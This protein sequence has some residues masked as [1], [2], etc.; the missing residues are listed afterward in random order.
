MTVVVWE[1]VVSPVMV[2]YSVDITP[3]CGAVCGAMVTELCPCTSPKKVYCIISD[4]RT[5]KW[6]LRTLTNAHIICFQLGGL[7]ANDL[8]ML[9]Q[10]KR[11]L[12]FEGQGDRA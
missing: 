9:M 3:D 4:T 5:F 11:S 7:M 8:Y 6:S 2:A 1:L 10:F 12:I